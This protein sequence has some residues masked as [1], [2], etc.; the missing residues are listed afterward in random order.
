MKR[1]LL[2]PR[3]E[4]SRDAGGGTAGP[5]ALAPARRVG[6][7][8][9]AWALV[10]L[11]GPGALTRD[12]S[13]LAWVGLA[14]WAFT[15]RRPGRR[16]F[17]AET[18]AG[19]FHGALTMYWV[20]HV[21]APAL[22]YVGLGWGLYLALTGAWLR[23]LAGRLPLA[24]AT[25]ASFTAVEALKAVLPPPFGLRWLQLGHHASATP[26]LQE[27]AR[28]WGPTGLTFVLAS[29]AGLAAALALGGGRARRG[30]WVTGLLPLG[31]ALAYAALSAAPA[32]EPG[33]RVLL[34][35]PAFPQWRKQAREDIREKFAE[36]LEL[37]AQGLRTGRA[38]GRPEP[39]L[40]CWGETMLY[41]TLV[42]GSLT[43]ADAAT[44]GELAVY[45]W[46][47][48]EEREFPAL[49]RTLERHERAWVGEALFGLGRAQRLLPEGTAFLSG[50]EIWFARDGRV[51][52]WNA[53]ALWGADGVRRAHSA[54][55]HLVPG[56][57]TMLGL[58]RLG[59]VRE[60]IWGVAGY[61]PDFTAAERTGVLELEARD[62]RA[63]R[64][65]ATV[66]FDNAFLRPYAEP[67]RRGPL[68]LHLVVSNE[69]WYRDSFEM[70]QMV[71]FSRLLAIATGRSFVRATNSGVTVAFGPD[72]RELAR[73]VQGGRDR[74]VPGTLAVEV[75]VPAR[76]P[77]ADEAP[78]ARTPFVWLEP[79]LDPAC[80]AL[81]ALLLLLRGRR[82]TG[83]G[84]GVG[85]G[86]PEGSFTRA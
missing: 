26:L 68:D 70:D 15:A 76:E 56:A 66:C 40:V 79:W 19:A 49:V 30:E 48:L 78:A 5:P 43:G 53:V 35:Q 64:I 54:K 86:D 38:V 74:H 31:V 29:L 84:S 80:V 1:A 37:T 63:Y 16:A 39:D 47:N 21:W 61:V 11:A 17:A 2:D 81:G 25:A 72:G 44:L 51:E 22:I 36:Q 8:L 62:G 28:L 3:A 82:V 75:P 18:L 33:P 60:F 42:D 24:L 45:P 20:A 4:A 34:V 9:L 77:G 14:L 65:G 58:E 50:A 59:G 83:A 52:H 41:A 12:G 73:L 69:A 13:A 6:W 71:A 23:R 10:L 46:W 27:S 7:L 67:L 85:G 55:Q 57:E 32:T